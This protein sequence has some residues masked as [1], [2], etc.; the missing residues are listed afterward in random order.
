[1]NALL[2]QFRSG[3]ALLMRCGVRI[4]RRGIYWLRDREEQCGP[5]DLVGYLPTANASVIY[6][7]VDAL[8]RSGILELLAGS[9]TAEEPDYQ[10]FVQRNE[11]RLSRMIW[12]QWRRR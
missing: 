3:I 8:R 9:K 11:V 12:M 1:M 4:G 5:S 10:Q 6:I 2:S 7:D